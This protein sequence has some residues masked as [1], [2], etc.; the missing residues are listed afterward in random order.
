MCYALGLIGAHN[1]HQGYSLSHNINENPFDVIRKE[2]KRQEQY[3]NA[4]NYSHLH[5]SSAWIT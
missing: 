2:P 4:M 5:S 3:V 1:V